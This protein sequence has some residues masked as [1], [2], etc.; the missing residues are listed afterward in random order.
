VRVLRVEPR[1]FRRRQP[2][3][4][5]AHVLH[6]L[7]RLLRDAMVDHLQP[8]VATPF[9]IY[10]RDANLDWHR[11]LAQRESNKGGEFGGRAWK[12]PISLP[13][14]RIARRTSSRLRDRSMM[15]REAAAA[16]AGG[17]LSAGKMK[18]SGR[19]AWIGAEWSIF[20]MVGQPA[21]EQ[22]WTVKEADTVLSCGLRP[23]R[24]A[25]L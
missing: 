16:V 22:R 7:H 14:S 2:E 21:R 19:V 13:A 24:R 20:S 3:E 11:R 6:V 15:G 8:A 25:I 5:P 4:L 10:H 12:K 17:R 1:L 9:A 18:Q 23:C